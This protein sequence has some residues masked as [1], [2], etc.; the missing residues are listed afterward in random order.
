M[1]ETAVLQKFELFYWIKD[2]SSTIY[3]ISI[4]YLDIFSPII[5]NNLRFIKITLKTIC[6]MTL[7][8]SY[9]K[10]AFYDGS[11]FLQDDLLSDHKHIASGPK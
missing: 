9:F 3:L 4:P 8:K 5:A 7:N 11:V 1:K 10:K 2:G 6:K